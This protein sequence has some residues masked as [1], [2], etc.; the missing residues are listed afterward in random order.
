MTDLNE[1][2]EAFTI[3]LIDQVEIIIDE[4]GLQ[5]VMPEWLETIGANVALL[6]SLKEQEDEQ[7]A[8]GVSDDFEAVYALL[9]EL[10][11]R[12]E[13]GRK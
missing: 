1:R 2:F 6:N 3:N 9:D 8:Y 13:E 7:A 4:L 11:K 10:K 5:E 12:Q